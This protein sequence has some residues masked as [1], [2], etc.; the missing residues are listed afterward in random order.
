MPAEDIFKDVTA[1]VSFYTDYKVKL[2]LRELIVGGIP[3]DPSV[4]RKWL[5][6]RMELDDTALHELLEQTIQERNAPVTTEEKVDILMKS[7]Q[8]PSVNGFKRNSRGELCYEGR[9]MKSALK[10]AANSSFPGVNYPGKAEAVAKGWV[11]ARKGLLSTLEEHV[12]VRENLISLGVTEPTRQEERIKHVMTPQGPRSAI[13]VVEVVH[14]PILE[15]TVRVH[16]DYLNREA[17]AKIWTRLEDLGIGSD[18]GRSDGSFDLL[19]F[20]RIK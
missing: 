19:E 15:C 8:A 4:I 18:R 2:Q 12:F 14:Q 7:A 20:S 5:E 13:A 10:E 11:G 1:N 9:N 6:A 16:D 17:W 3:S